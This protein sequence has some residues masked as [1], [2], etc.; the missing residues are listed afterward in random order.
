MIADVYSKSL[1]M[2]VP[3]LIE[4]GVCGRVENIQILVKI[5]QVCINWQEWIYSAEGPFSKIENRAKIRDNPPVWGPI[6]ELNR[7]LYRIGKT[8]FTI[9][10]K[11]E[12]SK[13]LPEKK[14]D[15]QS[16]INFVDLDFKSPLQKAIDLALIDH[17]KLS[18]IVY[19]LDNGANLYQAV[20]DENW[21]DKAVSSYLVYIF[22]NGLH[23]HHEAG[24][25]DI[26]NQIASLFLKQGCSINSLG[27]DGKGFLHHYIYFKDNN[28]HILN[29]YIANGGELNLKSK[30]GKTPIQE[31]LGSKYG[32]DELID[33]LLRL[34]NRGALLGKSDP[35]GDYPLHQVLR[36]ENVNR[37]NVN[38][39][40]IIL[41]LD[42]DQFYTKDASNSIPLYNAIKTGNVEVQNE[43]FLFMKRNIVN[44]Q[45]KE[46]EYLC[47]DSY[48]SYIQHKF[49]DR[50]YT[51]DE[52]NNIILRPINYYQKQE[53]YLEKG[54]NN[55]L[56]NLT[57][58]KQMSVDLLLLEDKEKNTFYHRLVTLC[59]ELLY[60]MINRLDRMDLCKRPNINGETILLLQEKSL[61]TINLIKACNE[62][63]LEE[64]K[65]LLNKPIFLDVKDRDKNSLLHLMVCLI[66]CRYKHSKNHYK[67][68]KLLL[69]QGLN[70]NHLNALGHSPLHYVG[71]NE[72][73]RVLLTFFGGKKIEH[74]L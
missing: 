41:K 45:T 60:L 71:S 55:L 1:T 5:S 7:H 22:R 16:Y 68:M 33:A 50:W 67:I 49:V 43:L 2:L 19:L 24:G 29:W 53:I 6:N 10:K 59:P 12:T 74:K 65:S 32:G 27:T 30:E 69:E 40:K 56:V 13:L 23:V 70:P 39:I 11:Y 63:N 47:L 37:S 15:I 54:L 35:N 3:Y 20:S 31:L 66:V 73:L 17:S 26:C 42:P 25:F 72:R 9:I 14:L 44:K 51:V 28:S 52:S 38:L 61:S 48:L 8:V 4:K 36:K 58:D 46:F 64:I 57:S 21:K 62:G 34:V 18:L